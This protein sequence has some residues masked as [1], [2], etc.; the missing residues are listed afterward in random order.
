MIAAQGEKPVI[1]VLDDQEYLAS[2]EKKLDEEAAEYHESKELE[3]LAD[4]LEVILALC[5]T[6]GHSLDELKTAYEK[7]HTECGG[8][9]KRISL[10]RK[11]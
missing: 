2:L 7:K 5:D 11:E 6:R 1:R 3:E 10:L 8:F 4:V 9:S